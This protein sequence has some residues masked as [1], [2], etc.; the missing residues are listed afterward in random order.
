MLDGIFACPVLDQITPRVRLTPRDSNCVHIVVA[1]K[2]HDYPLRITGIVFAGEWFCQIGIALPVS[3]LVTVRDAGIAVRIGAVAALCL[4]GA[5]ARSL[6]GGPALNMMVDGKVASTGVVTIDGRL[7]VPELG[8]RVSIMD[9]DDN[10][11]AQIGDGKGIDPKTIK[12]HPDKFATPHA[13]TVDSRGDL[14]VI[15]WLDF[16]RPRKFRHTPAA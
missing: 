6:A 7:Y 13:L 3:L 5:V 4:V 16:G 15:E 9:A 1:G 11:L 8:A 12:D 14:Y 10:F 2:V